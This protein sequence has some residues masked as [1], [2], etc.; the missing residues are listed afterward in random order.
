MK[1]Y[2]EFM[3]YV[4]ENVTDYLPKRF[5][6]AA[7]SIQ[8]VVK[9]NDVVL[10]ELKIQDMDSW[11]SPIIYLNSFYEEYKAG[12]DLDTLVSKVADIYVE[13]RMPDFMNGHEI[14][15]EDFTTYER[16]KEHILPKV[17]SLEKNKKRFEKIP[18]MAKEDLAITYYIKVALDDEKVGSVA[19]SNYLLERY[20]VSKEELHEVAMENMERLSPVSFLPLREVMIEMM[21][22]NLAESEGISV[23]EAKEYVN[24]M[25]P[26]GE[27]EIYCLTNKEKINGAAY[28]MNEEIQ[29]MVAQRVGGDYYVLPSSVHEVLIVKKSDAVSPEE[30]R[31]MVQ[32]VNREH[33]LPDEVLSDQVYQ[34]DVKEHKFGLCSPEREL[35][36]E[37]N[38]G[39]NPEPALVM[40]ST[41]TY[42]TKQSEH[43]HEPMKHDTRGR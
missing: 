19:I 7:I 30:L 17:V 37:K 22:K 41:N 8:Q 21:A 32:S 33:V 11:V 29:K 43:N 15:M 18:Y 13:N 28:I 26:S 14:Q 4:K 27:T 2:H 1:S 25:I 40:E 31:D 38:I 10:D 34:Y 36:Q 23:E 20:G 12:K 39:I 16:I 35:K 5:E 42:N 3:D 6:Y 24:D 9:N